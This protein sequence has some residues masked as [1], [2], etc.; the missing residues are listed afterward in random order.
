M[1]DQLTGR[2]SRLWGTVNTSLTGL[3]FGMCGIVG[4]RA[5]FGPRA[6]IG[7]ALAGIAAAIVGVTI[8][9]A[10]S[11]STRTRRRV[12]PSEAPRRLRPLSWIGPVVGGGLAILA[13]GGVAHSSGSGWVQAVGAILGGVLLTG[14]V[15]P[16]LPTSRARVTCLSSPA[17][18]QAGRP[19]EL[20]LEASGALRMTPRHP[21]GPAVHAGG[22]V[23]GPRPVA[24]TF[25]P[26]RR[27]VLENVI[28]EAA[29]SAPFGLL[30]WARDLEVALQRPLHVA[31]RSGVADPTGTS[32]DTVAGNASA[33]TSSGGGDPHGVRPYRPG[34]TRR[35][36]HWPAT[37]HTG[38]LMVREKERLVEDPPLI[39]A[40]LPED[41]TAAERRA[42]QIMATVSAELAA[43]RSVVLATT[44]PTRRV[45]RQVGDR[46]ELGR[47]LSRAIPSPRAPV[48]ERSEAAVTRDEQ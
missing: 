47:R 18:G 45:V 43:G 48:P 4:V 9:L 40:E 8:S 12:R 17:D 24:V 26:G 19:I 5:L 22:P 2:R 20:L 28:V 27:G 41:P 1:S 10:W 6:I 39:E 46:V 29:S 31:P 21:A 34:D 11:D 38:T 16:A 37:S 23:R 33:S 32:S 13:W 3:L 30:W 42:E 15:A 36:V 35:T 44:E 7:G 25:T 14:L